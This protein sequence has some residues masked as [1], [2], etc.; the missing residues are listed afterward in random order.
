MLEEEGRLRNRL[1]DGVRSGQLGLGLQVF[2]NPADGI[3]LAFVQREEFESV[4]ESLAISNDRPDFNR[5]RRQGQWNVER[6]DFPRL[7][8]SRQSSPDSILAHF[9]GTSPARAELA[10]LKHLY[11][12]TNINRETGEAAGVLRL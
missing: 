3:A 4:T 11:L 9:G 2:A 5:I 6:N 1:L 10:R 7:K 8:T 12:E